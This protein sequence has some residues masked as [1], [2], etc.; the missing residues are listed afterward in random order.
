M[1]KDTQVQ[2]FQKHNVRTLWDENQQI[3]LTV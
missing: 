3:C 1:H 2:L